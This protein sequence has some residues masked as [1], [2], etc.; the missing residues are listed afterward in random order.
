MWCNPPVRRAPP[1]LV[2][3][4]AIIADETQFRGL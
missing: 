1:D 2:V 3:V 4:L